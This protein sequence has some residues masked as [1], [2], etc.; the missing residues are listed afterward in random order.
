MLCGGA[1]GI[2]LILLPFD[3]AISGFVTPFRPGGDL[4]REM[5]LLQQFGSPT[6][7]IVCTLLIWRLDPRMLLKMLDW[8]L[9]AG[10]TWAAVF[11]LKASLGR[12]RPKFVGEHLNFLGPW[13]TYIVQEG[14]PPRYAW[15]I[16]ADD[17]TE[18]WSMPSSHTAFAVVAAVC[19]TRMYPRLRPIAIV[20]AVLVGVGRVLFKAH[21]PSDVLI[22]AAIG[23]AIAE[24]CMS[25]SLGVRLVNR[26]IPTPP[27]S[28]V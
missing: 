4:R 8:L 27:D 28:R 21:Y 11:A 22:G 9:A 1:A 7:M 3:G 2:A 12:P 19:L 13:N 18:I 5:E 6:T 25:R 26:L 14:D 17:V 15:E 10:M 16:L 20:M 24:V 23:Y